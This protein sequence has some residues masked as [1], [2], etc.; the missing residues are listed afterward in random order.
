M[1]DDDTKKLYKKFKKGKDKELIKKHDENLYA[2]FG[3]GIDNGRYELI[4][5]LT[6]K[7]RSASS[8]HYIAYAHNSGDNWVEF[9]DS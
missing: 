3:K 9:D 7:G 1:I 2:K 4:A 6:H 8:G 5:V